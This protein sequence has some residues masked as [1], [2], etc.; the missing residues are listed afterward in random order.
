[1]LFEHGL[2][3]IDTE[4]EPQVICMMLYTE[5]IAGQTD[6]FADTFV[7]KNVAYGYDIVRMLL[8]S[9]V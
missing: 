3:L 4:N 1:M 5:S 6:H 9:K 2:K 7:P 8:R